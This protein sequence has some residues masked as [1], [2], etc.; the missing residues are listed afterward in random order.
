MRR[1]RAALVGAVAALALGASAA[2]P[3]FAGWPHHDPQDQSLRQLAA[4]HG[5]KVGTAVN[6]DALADA[7]YKSIAA[8]Q[9]STV[10]AENVM[11][12]DTLE[13]TRGSYN[14]GP[15]EQ[16]MDFAKANHQQVRGHVLVWSNQLPQWLTQGVADGSITDTELRAILEEHVKTV[17]HHFKGRIW[18]WDVVNEAV[19]DS[20]DSPERRHRLQGLL[21]RA[22]RGR[23]RRRR[24]PLGARGRPE[25]A[26][27][28]QRLQHR[29]VR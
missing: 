15:A 11:K 21:V 5:L 25:G 8:T 26:A 2:V 17:V 9:F 20:W 19:T 3:A 29:R 7:Q 16:F 13:P 14:W 10:T 1:T 23:V 22:P 18:Q 6:V 28:L 12:W 27:V 24:V 4:R